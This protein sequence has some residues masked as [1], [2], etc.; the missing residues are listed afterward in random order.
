[1]RMSN[2]REQRNP[3]LL[4]H[5]YWIKAE[6]REPSD[7]PSVFVLHR[8]RNLQPGIGH[9]ARAFI[10]PASRAR[11]CC[12]RNDQGQLPATSGRDGARRSPTVR[13][14]TERR[15]APLSAGGSGRPVDAGREPDQVAPR[16][17]DLVLRAVPA[18]A[19]SAGL[20]RLRRRLRLSV[21]LLL[22]RGR[23]APC[24]APARPDHAAGQRPGRGLSRPCRRCGRRN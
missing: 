13:A 22:R 15:A 6:A 3:L 24:A 10:R 11:R 16:A 9:D 1:M 7:P 2:I 4:L 18:H 12:S 14:E 17:H 21:Q 8:L 5:V 20:P 19:A 23:P